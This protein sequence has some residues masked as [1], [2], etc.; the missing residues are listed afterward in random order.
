[1]QNSQKRDS[2]EKRE[3]HSEYKNKLYKLMKVAYL[4]PTERE[5]ISNPNLIYYDSYGYVYI[6]LNTLFTIN[7]LLITWL[8]FLKL[9]IK[10][11]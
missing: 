1:M 8:G 6:Q 5:L 11:K 10:M 7:Y 3:A 9:L 2:T 4:H